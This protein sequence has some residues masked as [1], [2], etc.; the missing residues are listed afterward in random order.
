MSFTVNGIT[1]TSKTAAEHAQTQL[2][3]INALRASRGESLLVASPSNAIWLELLAAGSLQQDYDDA[4]YAASKSWNIATCSDDQVLNLAPLAGTSQV[5]ATFSSVV[6]SITASSGG[7]AVIQAGDLCPFGAYN[8]VIQTGATVTA[9]ATLTFTAVC[10]TSGPINCA[11]GNIN[12]INRAGSPIANVGLV[13][14]LANSVNGAEIESI[15]S[16]RNRMIIGQGTIGWGLSGTILAIRALPGIQQAQVYFNPSTT[17][18][19][20]LPGGLSIPARHARIIIQ[21]SD[22]TGQLANTYALRMTA[23]TDGA[24]SENWVTSSMQTIPIYYDLASSQDV[25]IN[26]YYDPNYPT[27]TGF[28]N[29]IKTTIAALASQ[30]GMPITSQY[31]SESLNNFLYAKISGVTVSLDG[32][33]YSREAAI[34]ADSVAVFST[35]N[36]NVL[37]GP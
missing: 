23:P 6:V 24:Y 21:G 30:I 36:I 17:T 9:S 10:D 4:L 2:N 12:S 35:A 22:S 3:A 16:L 1:W 14:N 13:T 33:T 34:D 7:N 19:L 20:V 11:I 25:Y 37:S 8:F 28:A 26:V 15:T 31:I 18:A 27:Q 29:I 5:P 32:V